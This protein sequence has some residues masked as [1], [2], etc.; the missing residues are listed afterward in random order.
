MRH[1]ATLRLAEVLAARAKQLGGFSALA[2]EIED[3][4]PPESARGEERP[5]LH[6][7]RRKLKALA[8]GQ[9]TA[10]LSIVELRALDR[11]LDR[12]GEGLAYKTLFRKPDL[13]Q[14]LGDS[15]RVTFMLGARRE[16]Q[17]HWERWN[18]SHWDVLA[19]A[20]MQ[21]GINA[22]QS[23][24]RF[25]IQDVGYEGEHESAV[26]SGQEPAWSLLLDDRGPSVVSLGSNRINPATERMLCTM[27]GVRPF[28]AGRGRTLPFHFAWSSRLPYV[29]PSHLHY[30]PEDIAKRDGTAAKL[31]EEGEASVLAVGDEVLVD[32]VVPRQ[33]GDTYGVCIAQRRRRGQVW[34]V[35]AGVTG[36]AT[37]VAAKLANQLATRLHEKRGEQ[38]SDVYWAVVHARTNEPKDGQSRRSLGA[39]REFDEEEIL[40]GPEV[41]S[42]AGE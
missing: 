34:L 20:E 39:R 16:Q 38:H 31:V 3:A 13:M 11:Y 41:Y 37:F 14:A 7:D 17:Q 23:S 19:M 1:E 4:N 26:V 33:W 32:R 8:E 30:R 21:R 22:A 6:L 15:G 2:R 12:F 42:A 9:E 18:I 29:F 10:V 36:T 28:G 25:D 35:L 40:L 27:F 24:V 5:K